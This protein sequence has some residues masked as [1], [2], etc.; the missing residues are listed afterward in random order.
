MSS[1]DRMAGLLEAFLFAKG[2][3]VSLKEMA[4]ALEEDSLKIE[5]ALHVL[6]E[7]TTS[8]IQALRSIIR[9]RAGHSRRRR[10]MTNGSP[11]FWGNRAR[12][13]L[14]RLKRWLS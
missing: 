10:C 9:E 14:L 2:D 8:L 3:P 12:F 11:P 1:L 7:N 5:E 6:Q 13:P 4:E